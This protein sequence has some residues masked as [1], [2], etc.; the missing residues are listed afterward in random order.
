LEASKRTTPC[1][2]R[3]TSTPNWRKIFSVV[4]M[5]L[6]SGTLVNV[7]GSVARIAAKRIAI[8]K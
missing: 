1:A 5:S 6:R 3:S 4:S 7:T 2:L 8:Q